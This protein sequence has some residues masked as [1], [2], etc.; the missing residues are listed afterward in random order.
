MTLFFLSEKTKTCLYPTYRGP[1]L[2]IALHPQGAQISDLRN[3][4]VSYTHQRFLRKLD[5]STYSQSF[6]KS[7]LQNF[8]NKTSRE[9]YEI[10][11]SPPLPKTDDDGPMT[12]S[13]AKLIESQKKSLTLQNMHASPPALPL[14]KAN[15]PI[16]TLPEGYSEKFRKISVNHIKHIDICHKVARKEIILEDKPPGS[17][18]MII[19][20]S[21][22][23]QSTQKAK[24]CAKTV[25]FSYLSIRYF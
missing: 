25:R 4:K 3:N 13:R 9:P 1:Y 5:L 7:V 24:A 6:P 17:E 8:V 21:F 16:W 20:K 19:F 22:P 11:P 2:I 18:V 10:N 12:R 14:G 23:K 15:K